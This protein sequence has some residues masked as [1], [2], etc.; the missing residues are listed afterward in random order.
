MP[1]LTGIRYLE[2][3]ELFKGFLNTQPNGKISSFDS[4]RTFMLQNVGETDPGY[5][6]WNH[7]VVLGKLD[8]RY[9]LKASFSDAAIAFMIHQNR[10]SSSAYDSSRNFADMDS[11]QVMF[12]VTYSPI[13]NIRPGSSMTNIYQTPIIETDFTYPYSE[14][15]RSIAYFGNKPKAKFVT[16]VTNIGVTLYNQGALDE[17][18]T[19]AN[20]NRLKIHL[21]PANSTS[22]IESTDLGQRRF[23]MNGAF[24]PSAVRYP[25]PSTTT[26]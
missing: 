12:K 3:N 16:D 10:P 26:E 14:S 19:N 1:T 8:T 4:L 17:T 5:S 15:G 6:V 7:S 18:D 24:M 11:G 20:A 22:Y 13:A 2:L 23:L 9:V 21:D 25:L